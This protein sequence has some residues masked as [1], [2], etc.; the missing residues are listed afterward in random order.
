MKILVVGHGG[1]EHALLHKLR[2]DAPHARFWITHGNAGTH[3][4]AEP[5][6]IGVDDV[7]G[8]AS[9]ADGNSIDLVVIGPEAPLA[10]GLADAL[11]TRGLAAFGASRSATRIES[12]KAFAKALMRDAGVRT[13]AFR[14]FTSIE[15]ALEFIRENGA[16]IVVKASGLAAGKGAIVCDDIASAESAAR[17][18]LADET[19]G[20]AGSEIV[21]EQFLE[22]EELSIFA[23]TDGEDALLMLPAQDHKRIGEGD[24][25]PNTGGMGAY[26]PVSIGDEALVER[27]RDEVFEPVL[28]ALRDS[29]ASFRG[30]LYGGLMLTADG[31]QVIEFN[32][33]FGDP[34][35]QALLPLIDG[36]LLDPMFEIAKGGSIAGASLE[37]KD[38]A[39]LTTVLASAGYPERST[40]GIPITI[41]PDVRHEPDVF[42]FH[43]GTRLDGDTC[44]TDGGRV[45]A[46]TAV[47]RTLDEAAARSRR[48]AA[49][50]EFEGKQFRLD[51]GW[52]EIGRHARAARG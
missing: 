51:I 40:K 30:L 3:G 46:V 8:L 35:T 20:D 52:R 19:F 41:P 49:S 38:A 27:A 21:I 6:A 9:W 11:A 25:G 34:E 22:G 50:I 15:S 28:A 44:V 12:S 48:A 26:A 13:A 10:A 47:A 7:D 23:L 18:M 37:W 36:S 16:P 39:A 14:T 1:R 5:I 33:R 32:A 17:S 45:L 24:T 42:V 29:D 43:A 4:I 31:I 2:A